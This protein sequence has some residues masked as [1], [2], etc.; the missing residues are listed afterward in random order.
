MSVAQ[1]DLGALSRDELESLSLRVQAELRS[2]RTGVAH[3]PLGSQIAFGSGCI[4]CGGA[5]PPAE[6]AVPWRTSDTGRS[7]GQACKA[8]EWA[9]RKRGYKLSGLS[10]EHKQEIQRLRARLLVLL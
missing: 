6:A 7:R 3:N 9:L 2:R 1:L 5:R 4:V 10:A 8:C